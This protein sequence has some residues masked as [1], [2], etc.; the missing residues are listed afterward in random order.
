[1]PLV[2]LLGIG[3]RLLLLLAGLSL[4]GMGELLMLLLLLAAAAAVVACSVCCLSML[5]LF[6]S[7]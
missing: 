1:M 3:E 6:G 7:C 4:L 2:L 5:L